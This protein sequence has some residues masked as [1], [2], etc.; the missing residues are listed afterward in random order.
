ME[1]TPM[2]QTVAQS[3]T[4]LTY[5][6]FV[7]FPDDGK[8][9]EIID[10]EHYVTPSPNVRHQTIVVNLITALQAF[11]RER[12][13]GRV[14]VAPLDVLLSLH[15]IVEPDVLFVSTE[16]AGVLTSA[17]VRGAPDFAIEVLSPSTRR[18]DERLKRD[19]YERAGI[20]EYWLVDPEAET[21]KVFRREEAGYGRALLLSLR[22]GDV[23]TTP[24]LP[25]L[26]LPLIA[27][28]DE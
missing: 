25:G 28:F 17:N 9:H 18:R 8:R 4:K 20:T 13:I 23:L 16:R 26:E 10:G 24:L 11:V 5:E 7:L 27:V 14:F 6:D 15:D 12:R 3:T 2:E 22:E 1:G 19:L 21:V